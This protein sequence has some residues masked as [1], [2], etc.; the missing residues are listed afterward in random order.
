LAS[1]FPDEEIVEPPKEKR[2]MKKLMTLMLGVGLLFGTVASLSAR[3]QEPQTT[4]KK[5]AKK[6]S[7]KTEK[8]EEKK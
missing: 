3:P 5:K 1:W 2:T 6:G 7:K 4:G 8:K